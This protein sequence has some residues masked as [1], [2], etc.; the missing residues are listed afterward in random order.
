MHLLMDLLY[1]R[2]TVWSLTFIPSTLWKS[3]SDKKKT[4][5][6]IYTYSK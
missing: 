5:F 6:G 4:A 3:L 1:L 2:N